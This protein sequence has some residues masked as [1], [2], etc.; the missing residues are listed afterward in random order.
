MHFIITYILSALIISYAAI[1]GRMNNSPS[2][3]KVGFLKGILELNR[4]GTQDWCFADT[5]TKLF[6]SDR[7]RTG[8]KS[9]AAINMP[10]GLKLFLNEES[11]VR[12]ES[13]SPGR[14]KV[15]LNT[16]SIFSGSCYI[17][18]MDESDSLY[19][20]NII[21]PSALFTVRNGTGF[22][23]TSDQSSNRADILVLNGTVTAKNIS[24]TKEIS[25][26]A[27][28]TTSIEI[29]REIE[30]SRASDSID[31]SNLSWINTIIPGLVIKEA[32][33]AGV[34]REQTRAILGGNAEDRIVVTC[35]TNHSDYSGLWDIEKALSSMTA[36]ILKSNAGLPIEL[37]GSH[38]DEKT[39]D[40]LKKKATI[41]IIGNI[42]AFEL[43]KGTKI[44]G[45][46]GNFQGQLTCRLEITFTLISPADN[47]TLTAF[48]VTEKIKENEVPGNTFKDIAERPFSMDDKIF[49]ESI[50]GRTVQ[51]V[52]NKML[53]QMKGYLSL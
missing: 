50:I 51:S 49:F 22:G 38:P 17:M 27:G 35:F 2:I 18:T 34:K 8:R 19:Q 53:S 26:P 29:G 45:S 10:G 28:K 7:I 21:T 3:A 40:S 33:K 9:I 46:K 15:N 48:A 41:V 39:I 37:T 36:N 31:V 24:L 25:I 43:S 42:T 30:R 1:P 13:G 16:I 52:M 47:R 44:S 23:I 32:N 11:K 4:A 5:S 6:D 12:I 20:H 14:E